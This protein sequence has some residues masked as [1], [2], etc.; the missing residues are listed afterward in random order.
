MIT[1]SSPY[2]HS[3]PLFYRLK[4]LKLVDIHRFFILVNMFKS[5]SNN[6]YKI[7]HS[8]NTRNR[9]LAS[10]KFH[11]LTLTRHGISYLG[12]S[13][14]NKLPSELREIESLPVFKKRLKIYLIDQYSSSF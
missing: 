9:H 13:M 14:W 12:P 3:T 2:E 5:I 6:M 10:S 7:E 4:I 1:N 11:R 8:V